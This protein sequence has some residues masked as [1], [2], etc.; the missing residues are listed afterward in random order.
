MSKTTEIQTK[1]SNGANTPLAFEPL[2]CTVERPLLRYHGGKWLLA[3]WILSHFPDHRI[4]VEPFGGAASVLLQKRRSYAE[5]YNDLDDEIVNLF[6]IVR[7]RGK[8]LIHAL[9]YTP[10]SR[11]EFEL[12]YQPTEDDFERARRT[13]IRSFMGFGSS[14]A[15]TTKW[16][17]SSKGFRSKGNFSG[18]YGKPTTGFRSNS[19]RSGTTP[20]HDWKNYPD[21][22]KGI[23]ERLRGV[24]I[25]NR[26]A[27]KVMAQHDT[28][29]TLHYV[30]PPYVLSTRYNGEK[31]KCYNF[32]MKDDQH[33]ELCEFLKQL[34]GT[35]ILSGYDNELYND[36]L[37]GWI[38]HHRKAY[39]DGAKERKEVLWINRQEN[40]AQMSLAFN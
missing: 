3:P 34:N 24:V 9:T 38:K 21:A 1:I 14:A 39:A 15:T 19:N 36:L 28:K 35:V 20:A 31:T 26:D 7:E 23:I 16:G 27:K 29:N 32:E 5:V 11:K 22:L 4:Y 17:A 18:E 40:D 13:V 10:F 6:R 37:K 25:E 12:S 2:L 30:D 8:E 33:V